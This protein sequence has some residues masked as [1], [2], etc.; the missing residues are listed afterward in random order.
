MDK[1]IIVISVGGSLI[2]PEKADINFLK[3]FKDLILE[4]IKRGKRF[5]II[6]GGGRIARDY[7]KS[8]KVVTELTKEDIDWLGIHCT[9]LNAHLLR[10][11]FCGWAHPKI[12]KNPLEKVDFKEKILIASGWKP[13]CSTDYDAVLIARKLGIKKLVN[14]T[15]IDYVY[16]KNPKKFR[17]AKPLKDLSWKEFR[18]ILPKKWN[19]GLN[20]PFDPVAAKEAEKIGLEVAIMDGKNL[21]NFGD[22]LDDKEFVGT[23]VS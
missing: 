13:G 20:A 8:A 11:I 4:Y 5:V 22:Y 12:I 6:C 19:P 10:A 21:K 16:N 3:A 15:D 9:R 17:D 7:Q 1:N 14:L 23:K 2:V 18:N